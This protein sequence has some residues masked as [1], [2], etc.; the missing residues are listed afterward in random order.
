MT[1]VDVAWPQ[2]MWPGR[3]GCSM[4]SVDMTL[5][6]WVWHGLNVCGMV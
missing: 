6:Q 3:S 2:W 4:A 5:P 1:S